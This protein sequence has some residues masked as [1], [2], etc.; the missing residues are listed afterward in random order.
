VPRSRIGGA[1][2]LPSNTPSWRDA[3]VKHR[4]RLPYLDY[5]HEQNIPSDHINDQELPVVTFMDEILPV[6]I[7]VTKIFPVAIFVKREIFHVHIQE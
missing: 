4:D 6:V 2:P 1:I 5:I 3:Q 7:F